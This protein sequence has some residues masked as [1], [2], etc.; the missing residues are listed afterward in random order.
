MSK[1]PKKS[2]KKEESFEQRFHELEEIVRQ[3]E[4]GTVDLES[5]IQQFEKGLQIAKE[6]QST[7][8]KV[9]NT[10]VSLKKK[11]QVEE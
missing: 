1:T 7:L 8:E 2:V 11:Y 4:Q 5:S 6:L 3:F 10:I 9:E